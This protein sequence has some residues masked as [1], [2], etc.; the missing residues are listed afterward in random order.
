MNNGKLKLTESGLNAL[1]LKI[2]ETENR[3]SEIRAE[4]EV[5]YWGSG[6]GWHDNPGFNQL[7]QLEFRVCSE[8]QEMV[9]L[10]DNAMIVR[11]IN[12]NTKTVSIG[13]IVKIEQISLIDKSKRTIIWEIVGH[14]E[15]D[16]KKSKIAYDTPI[17][18]V[19]LDKT[20]GESVELILPGGRSILKI[21][22]LFPCWDSVNS[23]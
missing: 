14:K 16:P 22:E 13:S 19:I 21:I 3:I 20:I 1:N 11:L 23:K 4:K 12:R 18:T 10:R 5:A 7:E 6:D 2:I 9:R 17:G 15:S 8:L